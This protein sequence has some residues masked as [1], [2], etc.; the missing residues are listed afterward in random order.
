M[1]SMLSALKTLTRG[2]GHSKR[3]MFLGL[4][5]AGKTTILYKL[6]LGEVVTTIPTIGFNVETILY[7]NLSLTSWDVGGKDKIRPLWRHYFQNTEALIFVVDASDHDRIEDARDELHRV[8]NEPQL[9][10]QNP[11]ILIMLNKMDLPNVLTVSE[12]REKLDVEGLE[13]IYS[14]VH[15]QPTIGYSG[16]GLYEG[17]EY[18]SQHFSKKTKKPKRHKMFEELKHCMMTEFK[19]LPTYIVDHIGKYVSRHWDRISEQ[20][21]PDPAAAA[22]AAAAATATSSSKSTGNTRCVIC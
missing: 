20:P 16:H 1:G 17:L 10:E 3:M 8:A 9:L 7:K 18:I 19:T 21:F 2:S 6:K 4:D 15:M 13:W 14:H 22:A 5:A 12:A 11:T